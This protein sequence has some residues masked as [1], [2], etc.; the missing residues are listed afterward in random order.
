MGKSS[1]QE[2]IGIFERFIFFF[3]WNC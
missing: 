3:R 1:Q 2:I